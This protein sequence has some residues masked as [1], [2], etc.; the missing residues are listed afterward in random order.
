[1]GVWWVLV[2]HLLFPSPTGNPGRLATSSVYMHGIK[3]LLSRSIGTNRSEIT[4]LWSCLFVACSSAL[5]LLRTTSLAWPW[6]STIWSG[7]LI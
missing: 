7:L 1:M 5:Y 3:R 4:F 2:S 6:R